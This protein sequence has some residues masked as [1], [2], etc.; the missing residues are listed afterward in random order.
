MTGSLHLNRTAEDNSLSKIR[1]Y[2]LKYTI[3]EGLASEIRDYIS[4]ICTLD[5]HVPP[6][7]KGYIVNNLYFD[8]DDL[9]FYHDTKHRKLT[10]YK[11]RARFY[12]DKATDYIWPE[13]KFRNASV[14]WKLRYSIPVE[15]WPALFTGSRTEYSPPAFKDRF[16]TF[17]EV[18]LLAQRATRAPRPL[19][20]VNPMLPNWKH[21]AGSRS[22]AVY[23]AGPPGVRSISTS[24]SGTCCITMTR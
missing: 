5:K 23:A 9:R 13:I 20:S 17:D 12:G 11:P 8:T 1:R 6:G 21:T 24:T 4:T 2:E 3:T 15:E 18:I 7:E 19:F 10:R 22:I 16:E 14:I